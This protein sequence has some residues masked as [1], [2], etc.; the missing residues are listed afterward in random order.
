MVSFKILTGTSLS[1]KALLL[2]RTKI[3]RFISSDKTKLKV[4]HSDCV[5]FE[6]L[7]FSM[8]IWHWGDFCDSS[9]ILVYCISSDRFFRYKV[10]ALICQ[11]KSLLLKNGFIFFQSFVLSFIS[12]TF[13]PV[14]MKKI[15]GGP[16][17]LKYCQLL[18]LA[19][20]ENFDFKSSKRAR[21][22]YI[23]R[24]WVM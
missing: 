21:K 4:N 13:R 24:R 15:L 19:D 16:P 18:W 23:C 11:F 22:I 20:E 6:E 14:E 5:L 12:L 7:I 1:L 10:L 3:S 9:K 17:N 8:S 2:S